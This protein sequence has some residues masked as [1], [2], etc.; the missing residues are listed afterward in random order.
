MPAP[1]SPAGTSFAST[2]SSPP[3]AVTVTRF[4][5]PVGRAGAAGGCPADVGDA[6]GDGC[7]VAVGEEAAA[8]ELR[9][10]AGDAGPAAHA[11]RRA[12]PAETP[13]A[14]RT[15]RSREVW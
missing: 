5:I 6:L 13:T 9:L 15:R 10:G 14:R 3:R 11:P 12:S 2:S 4:G 7:G 1:S 8:L